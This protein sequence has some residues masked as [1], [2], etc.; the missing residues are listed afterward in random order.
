MCQLNDF[1]TVEGFHQNE[2]LIGVPDSATHIFPWMI[3]IG[4]ANHDF[5]RRVDI[6][7]I[8]DR[9]ETIPP[10]RHT[11]IHKRQCVGQALPVRAMDHTAPFS[12]LAREGQFVA[13]SWRKT[14]GLSE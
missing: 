12:P 10:R 14:W 3:G 11:H 7:Q 9:F 13:L 2:E 8:L 1:N 5:K 6:P 4:S